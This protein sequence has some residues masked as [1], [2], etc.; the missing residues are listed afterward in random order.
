LKVA[1]NDAFCDWGTPLQTGDAI[2]FIPP[3]AGG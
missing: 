3:V 2:V 1:I